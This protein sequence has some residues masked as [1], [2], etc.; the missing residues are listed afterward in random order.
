MHRLSLNYDVD[1][2]DLLKQQL[3]W[4]YNSNMYY[5]KQMPLDSLL[6]KWRQMKN[7]VNLLPL[8]QM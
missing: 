2:V 8:K 6:E 3:Q 5:N 1:I 4:T 7:L